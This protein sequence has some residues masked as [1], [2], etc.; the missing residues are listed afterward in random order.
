MEF[1]TAFCAIIG[2]GPSAPDKVSGTITVV[3]GLLFG[4]AAITPGT[5]VRGAFGRGTGE[6]APLNVAGRLILVTVSLVLLLYGL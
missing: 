2:R 5:R 6:R 1:L 3:V 4:L